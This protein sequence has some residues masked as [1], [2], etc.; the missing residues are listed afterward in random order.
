VGWSGW[1]DLSSVNIEPGFV[2]GEDLSGS[3][4]IFGV[5]SS[6]NVWHNAQT[7]NGGWNSADLAG[8]QLSP[9]L[10]VARNLDGRLEVFGVDDRGTVWHNWQMATGGTW[11]GRCKIP[12]R[13]LEPGFAVGQIDD[14]RL[15]MFG[16]T[17]HADLG[18]GRGTQNIWSIS[19]ETA[20]G[21][22]GGR[23]TDLGGFG[24]DQLLV[25][26]TLDGR[27]QLFGV[28][29]NGDIWSDWQ[30]APRGAWSGWTDFGGAGINFYSN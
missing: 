14:G 25:S 16:V 1:S 22:F 12:G 27:I 11:N 13:R 18:Q 29:R 28:G 5:D 19:Q 30:Q 26:N 20:G 8:I 15:E 4:E 17:R 21:K 7:S 3:L 24:I 2:I 6:G 10:A 9:R 23:W